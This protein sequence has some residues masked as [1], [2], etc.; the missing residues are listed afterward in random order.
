MKIAAIEAGGTKFVCAIVNDKGEVLERITIPTTTPTETMR[1]VID[2]FKLKEFSVIGLG[3]FGPIDLNKQSKTYGYI[4]STPKVAWQ[5]YN[6]LGTLQEAFDVKIGL[7]T[8]VNGAALGEYTFGSA[9]RVDS[10]LYITVGTGI[11]AGAVI[12][13]KMLNGLMHPEM[14]H[15]KIKRHQDDDFEG[16]CPF[17][18]DCLEG[19]AAGPAI[20]ARVGKKANQLPTNHPIWNLESYYLAQALMNYILVLSPEKIILGGGVMHQ[21][22]LYAMIRKQLAKQLNSYIINDILDTEDYITK[23]Q[24][25]NDVGII[26]CAMIGLAEME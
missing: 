23:P 11:G 9:K 10:C 5:N 20:E 16:M 15:I 4:T 25:G 17:H 3:C 7:D 18:H 13:G 6:I 22:H 12:N 1:K 14:G 2:F 21:E 19:L 24:L 26:G 8:D